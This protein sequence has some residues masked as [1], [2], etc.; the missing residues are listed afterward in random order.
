MTELTPAIVEEVTKK[1]PVPARE[2]ARLV[3]L[4]RAG[5]TGAGL[6]QRVGDADLRAIVAEA[7][8]AHDADVAYIGTGGR[9]AISLACSLK[10]D[11][12]RWPGPVP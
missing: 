5:L 6:A 2:P 10:K 9:A 4:Q 1:M 12:A 3:A 7:R 11:L 8:A